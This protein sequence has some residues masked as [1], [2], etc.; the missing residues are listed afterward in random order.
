LR[1]QL[2]LVSWVTD[3]TLK[4]DHSREAVLYEE[5]EGVV[6][7][8]RNA[9]VTAKD[10]NEHVEDD[11]KKVWVFLMVSA[12]LHFS[13]ELLTPSTSTVNILIFNR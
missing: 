11:R 5:Q 8:E 6:Q 10:R 7:P 1:K 4:E 12:A 2:L 9:T 3:A 13:A